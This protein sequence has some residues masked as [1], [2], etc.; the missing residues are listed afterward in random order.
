MTQA[1]RPVFGPRVEE[2]RTLAISKSNRRK[3][4]EQRFRGR[5]EKLRTKTDI[6]EDGR[7]LVPG[8]REF[9]REL[10]DM[11]GRLSDEELEALANVEGD[12]IIPGNVPPRRP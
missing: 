5:L 9:E 7:K 8:T 12:L 4:A 3:L 11:A 6:F 2:R 1:E 10:A